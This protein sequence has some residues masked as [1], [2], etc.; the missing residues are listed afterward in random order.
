MELLSRKYGK[1]DF[2]IVDSL[3]NASEGHLLQVLEEIL[4]LGLDIR[5]SCYLQPKISDMSIIGLLKRAGCVAIDFG[6]DSGSLKM[7]LSMNKCFIPEDIIKTS[8]AC[9]TEGIDF[10]HSLILGGPGETRETIRET[11]RLMDE[12]S[13]R[14]VVAMTGVR[15]YP[16][17]EMEVIARRE[18]YI[19]EGESLLSPH[20]YFSELGADNLMREVRSAVG[21]RRNWFFPGERNRS[22]SVCHRLLYF[23]YRN[24]PLWRTFKK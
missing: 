13:P 23:L 11:V 18:G 5:F 19:A 17:T 15:I 8:E 6:T 3:F 7:L 4:R 10:C 14:A 24:G 22:A 1:R 9:I 20:F 16:G 21:S 12:V 2:F